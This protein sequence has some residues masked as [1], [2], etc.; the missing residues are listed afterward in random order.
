MRSAT[1]LG[2]SSPSGK[3]SKYLIK[4][5]ISCHFFG[6]LCDPTLAYGTLDYSRNLLESDPT[7]VCGL[8]KT[9]TEKI[10]IGV[11]FVVREL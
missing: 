4:L 10:Q 3:F 6:L 1:K 5:I 7:L 9:E 11:P 2:S 8:T